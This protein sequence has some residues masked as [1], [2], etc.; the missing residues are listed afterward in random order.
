MIITCDHNIRQ[1]KTDLFEELCVDH[2]KRCCLENRW[3]TD[4][5]EC[6]GGVVSPCSGK[7]R[8]LVGPSHSY[9]PFF[10]NGIFEIVSFEL[11]RLILIFADQISSYF[12]SQFNLF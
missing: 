9:S 8:C 6:P 5:K 7:G 11:D 10:G 4:C 12:I 1:D 2:L 3:G